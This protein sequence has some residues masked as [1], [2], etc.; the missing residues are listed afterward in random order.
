MHTG[1]SCVPRH[2]TQMSPDLE[3]LRVAQ[4]LS[5]GHPIM[6]QGLSI[7]HPIRYNLMGC[8]LGNACTDKPNYVAQMTGVHNTI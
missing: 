5:I 1:L 3:P 6:W 7:E 8:T 4:G 2:T